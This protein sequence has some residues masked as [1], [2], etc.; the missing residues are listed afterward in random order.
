M[1]KNLQLFED[2]RVKAEKE[3]VDRMKR[4]LVDLLKEQPEL[5]TTFHI[6]RFLHARENDY[7][8]AKA[9]FQKYLLFRKKKNVTRVSA[10]D[11]NS[12][13]IK[14]LRD[15]YTSGHYGHD[16]EGRLLVIERVGFYD[17]KGMARD[18]TGEELEDYL[19]QIQERALFIELP[20][21]SEIFQKRIDRTV[22][23][24][25]LKNLQINKLFQKKFRHFMDVALNLTKE[26]Y[27]ETLIKSVFINAPFGASAAWGIIKFWLDPK[28]AAKFEMCTDDGRKY[29]SKMLNFDNLPVEIGGKN[30]VSLQYG[31]GPTVE[32]L[33]KSYHRKSLFLSNREVEYK[34]FYTEEERKLLEKETASTMNSSNYINMLP[35]SISTDFESYVG[36]SKLNKSQKL[37]ISRVRVNSYFEHTHSFR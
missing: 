23:I 30:T 3:M 24:L 13:R 27:P 11:M 31:F 21:L 22:V 37:N 12:E 32:E 29:L 34:W 19:M 14:V 4:D 16:N 26:Y 10:I 36:K 9:M 17:V 2:L 7:E 28:T 6:T 35:H 33:R 25:D 1:E 18:F 5:N 8:K 20:I 15:Y